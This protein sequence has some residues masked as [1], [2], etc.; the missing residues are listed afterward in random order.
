VALLA[1][2][3]ERA[4]SLAERAVTP[5]PLRRARGRADR[6]ATAAIGA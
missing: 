2:V 6:A 1:L 4:L 5:R 3:V